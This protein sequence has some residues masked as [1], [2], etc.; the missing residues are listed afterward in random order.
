[1]HE[2]GIDPEKVLLSLNTVDLTRVPT[3][4]VPISQTVR[5]ALCFAGSKAHVPI[6]RAACEQR[7]IAFDMLGRCCDKISA[8]P[9]SE[10]IN[11]DLVFATGRSAIEALCCGASVV[12]CDDRGLGGYVNP[13]NYE[14]FRHLNFALRLLTKPVTVENITAELQKYNAQE[15]TLVVQRARADCALEPQLDRFL[16]IYASIL[17]RWPNEAINAE[18]SRKAMLDFLSEALP[19]KITDSRWPWMVEREQLIK[20]RDRLALLATMGFRASASAAMKA[21]TRRISA[22]MRNG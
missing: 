18:A 9:E 17:T 11:Y 14:R 19:R 5:R 10:L 12:V 7:G 3:R 13:E 15:A 6:L 16:E 4:Q 22:T 2:E 20:E 21:L 1:V 8:H